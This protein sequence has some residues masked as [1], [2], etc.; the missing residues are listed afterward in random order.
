MNSLLLH[1]EFVAI[2]LE[3]AETRIILDFQTNNRPASLQTEEAALR[4]ARVPHRAADV[5]RVPQH[6]HQCEYCSL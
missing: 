2:I 3:I 4:G 5:R 6:D 1:S